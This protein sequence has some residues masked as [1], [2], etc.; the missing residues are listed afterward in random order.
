MSPDA[1]DL[2]SPRLRF[3]RAFQNAGA[4]KRFVFD[5]KG[6]LPVVIRRKTLRTTA[7]LIKVPSMEDATVL[8]EHRIGKTVTTS[9]S[10]MFTR[11]VQCIEESSGAPPCDFC[12]S[13]AGIWTADQNGLAPYA[14]DDLDGDICTPEPKLTLHVM[15]HVCC[16][17]TTCRQKQQEASLDLMK[18][19]EEKTGKEVR[20][21]LALQSCAFCFSMAGDGK[22]L[23]K[24][25]GCKL[26]TYCSE[27]C[28]R[29]DWK[30]SHKKVCNQAD[31]NHTRD[32]AC[33]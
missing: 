6:P 13:T 21:P 22:T 1:Q 24:C 27:A 25:M 5:S 11:W 20:V 4:W 8:L 30:Q 26:V 3:S 33:R 23:R 7:T 2:S 14:E 17:A 18:R 28:Q 10:R 29:A 15:S 31:P 16:G 32:R 19:C 12:E 9:E